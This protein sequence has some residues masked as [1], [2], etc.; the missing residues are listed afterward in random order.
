MRAVLAGEGPL[1]VLLHGFPDFW[2]G[3]RRQIEALAQA[4]F[5]VVVPDLRGYNLSDKPKGLASYSTDKLVSDVLGLM[6]HLGAE[7]ASIVGHDW[8]GIIAWSV[9]RR[10]PEKVDK[11]VVL[12][13]PHPGAYVEALRG[14]AQILKSWYVFAFAVPFIP[15]RVLG[16]RN[17]ALIG[18]IFRNG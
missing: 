1:V 5:R 7:T 15:E 17:S 9:A 16:A 6:A 12:N 4:G 13:A 14:T 2:L 11:L 10:R 18:R 8:G 3:W